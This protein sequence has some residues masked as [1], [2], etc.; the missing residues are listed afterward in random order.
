MAKDQQHLETC[1]PTLQ[2]AVLNSGTRFAVPKMRSGEQRRNIR[3]SPL[4]ADLAVT[5][6][7][8]KRPPILPHHKPYL[9]APHRQPLRL[10]QVSTNSGL[11]CTNRPFLPRHVAKIESYGVQIQ[12]AKFHWVAFHLGRFSFGGLPFGEVSLGE[13]SRWY[14]CPN[15]THM[16]AL[17]MYTMWRTCTIVHTK[18][19]HVFDSP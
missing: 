9:F 12:L 6:G 1:A 3:S 5:S 17:Y 11:F 13:V 16:R 2:N 14:R 10:L 19:I 7:G 4:G 8:K 18:N 15:H